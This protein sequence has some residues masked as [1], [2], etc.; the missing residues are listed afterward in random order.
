MPY[1]T[2]PRRLGVLGVGA[3]VLLCIGAAF[4]N[5]VQRVTMASWER[6]WA[7]VEPHWSGRTPS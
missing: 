2:L 4:R 7:Q 3:A 6:E 1:D 5:G